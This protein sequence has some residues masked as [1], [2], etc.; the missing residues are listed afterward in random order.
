MLNRRWILPLAFLAS[1]TSACWTSERPARVRITRKNHGQVFALSGDGHRTARCDDC[2]GS[3]D[4]FTRATCTE[5]CHDHA[6]DVTT[7]QHAGVPGYTPDGERCVGCHPNGQPYRRASHKPPEIVQAPH[8]T[9][10][11]VGCH[12]N[13]TTDFSC[14]E[15]HTHDAASTD[16]VHQGVPDYRYESTA[17]YACHPTGRGISPAE[18]DRFFPISTGAHSG[19]ECRSCHVNDYATFSCIDCH[20]HDAATTDPQHQGISGYRYATDAC[21]QC[22]PRGEAMSR[23][24]HG[25]YFP[26][27][28]GN[29]R[30]TEC[31]G[32]HPNGYGSYVCFD[33]HAHTC[34][35]MS[36]RHG[37][38]RSFS[39]D[40]SACRS[41]HPRGYAE[42]D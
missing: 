31:Q 26:I 36:Y 3:F 20:T 27:S 35:A 37:E 24:D 8:D 7:P 23:A 10:P 34:T 41:C 16:P 2:H 14:T 42:D 12:T 30:A 1:V 21:I 4:T 11:C 18:H 15:C 39:C 32:C 5:G 17:C 38:V 40:D 33:C 25:R 19:L 28:S 13:A 9:I 6:L 22:H 29:H